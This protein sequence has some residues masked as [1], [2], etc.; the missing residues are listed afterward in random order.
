MGG[1]IQR[2]IFRFSQPKK[3]FVVSQGGGHVYV[4]VQFTHSAIIFLVFFVSFVHV[5]PIFILDIVLSV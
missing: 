1:S 5:C 4:R 3:A 2:A